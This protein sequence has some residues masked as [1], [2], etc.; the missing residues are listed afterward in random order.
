MGQGL[1]PPKEEIREKGNRGC[2][3]G[4]EPLDYRVPE[5]TK[6]IDD[7]DISGI[8]HIFYVLHSRGKRWVVWEGKDESLDR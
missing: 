7:R 8:P 6:C 3:V 5:L 2:R 1:G 4:V